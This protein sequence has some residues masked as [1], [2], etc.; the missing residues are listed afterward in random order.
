MLFYKLV[1]IFDKSIR[2]A[3]TTILVLKK[4]AMIDENHEY[5]SVMERGSSNG[6]YCKSYHSVYD[7][8]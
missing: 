8:L 6:R 2:K 4:S 5:T 3:I 7:D 1:C